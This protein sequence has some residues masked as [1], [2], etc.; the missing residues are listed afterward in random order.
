MGD[1]R[2]DLSCQTPQNLPF[3]SN[4]MDQLLIY[5]GVLTQFFISAFLQTGLRVMASPGKLSN[6]SG[7]PRIIFRLVKLIPFAML[8]DCVGVHQVIC[9]PFL[10][11]LPGYQLPEV[12]GRLHGYHD[13]R[14]LMFLAHS[15]QSPQ[16]IVIASPVLWKTEAVQLFSLFIDHHNHILLQCQVNPHV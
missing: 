8:L 14:C 5:G 2:K 12:V 3:A 13:H 10:F 15:F 7:I 1:F 6:L 16:K 4:G 11:Q 9:D